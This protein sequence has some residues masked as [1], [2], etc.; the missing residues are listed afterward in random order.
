[1]EKINNLV[2]ERI[3][4]MCEHTPQEYMNTSQIYIAGQG[5]DHCNEGYDGRSVV[6]E[7][8]LPDA[9]FM[10][11]MRENNRNK[12]VQYWFEELNGIDLLGASWL[13]VLQGTLSPIDVERNVHL[14]TPHEAHK[15]ALKYWLDKTMPIA[16]HTINQNSESA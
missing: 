7:I 4:N 16:N 3:M 6:A 2:H 8:I 13:R 9:E 11:L 5:C 1:M 10:R 14:F 15:K 12:A